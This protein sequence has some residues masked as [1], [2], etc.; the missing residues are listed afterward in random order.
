MITLA[1]QA[2]SCGSDSGPRF[3][4]R[5]C[6][7]PRSTVRTSNRPIPAAPRA[8][9]PQSQ[10]DAMHETIVTAGA[11]YCK[12]PTAESVP[13]SPRRNHGETRTAP[14][15]S[16]HNQSAGQHHGQRSAADALYN[17]SRSGVV[18]REPVCSRARRGLGRSVECQL[19]DGSG[20]P[21]RWV[22]AGP[23]QDQEEAGAER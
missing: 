8:S 16:L 13:G 11:D 17:R 15:P 4:K 3:P 19:G 22:A 23:G 20:Q 21:A 18:T 2:G 7:T 12:L 6:D 10:P 1:T 5:A 9:P 14:E